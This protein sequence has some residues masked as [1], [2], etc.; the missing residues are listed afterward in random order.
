MCACVCVC[1]FHCRPKEWCVS[2]N[3]KDPLRGSGTERL[4][5]LGVVSGDLL[6][7]VPTVPAPVEVDQSVAKVE[8][9][10][11]AP[12]ELDQSGTKMESC[13]SAPKELDQSGTKMESRY[14]A[15]GEV[16]RSGTKIESRDSAPREL[17]QS[18]AKMESC[19]SAPPLIVSHVTPPSRF[20]ELL[21]ALYMT[22]APRTAAEVALVVGDAVLISEGLTREKDTTV[23]VNKAGTYRVRY[24]YLGKDCHVAMT[25]MGRI[26]VIQGECWPLGS[27]PVCMVQCDS[28]RPT[29]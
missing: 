27:V 1:V 8:S 6:W 17:D 4:V 10:D 24:S 9:C 29:H 20:S 18:V 26:C 3:G 19:D 15:P 2:L 23:L 25:T 11:S 13:D 12:I 7:L 22:A 5:E 28:D 21:T 14:S 16:G